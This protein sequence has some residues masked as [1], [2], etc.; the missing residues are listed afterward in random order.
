MNKNLLKLLHYAGL[1]N[2]TDEQVHLYCNL[3][4]HLPKDIYRMVFLL[5]KHGVSPIT[6][7][8]LIKLQRI[9]S[10]SGAFTALRTVYTKV[11]ISDDCVG[12]TLFEM[13]REQEKRFDILEH[14]VFSGNKAIIYL[15]FSLNEDEYIDLIQNYNQLF[16]DY[17]SVGNSIESTIRFIN[18]DISKSA[19][20]WFLNK[21]S[22]KFAL[23]DKRSDKK[24]N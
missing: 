20:V 6:L 13:I 17:L 9:N 23:K 14:N 24:A 1:T 11:R 5:E 16:L 10:N 12:R 15:N 19:T 4:K 3:G 21:W 8:Y 7:D 22:S 18:Q 2:L